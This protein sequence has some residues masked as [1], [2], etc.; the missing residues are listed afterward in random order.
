[1]SRCPTTWKDCAGM[2]RF[3]PQ[4]LQLGVM[5]AGV[6]LSGHALLLGAHMAAPHGH[7]SGNAH[8]FCFV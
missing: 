7:C 1:M 4:R 6:L 3:N 5:L 8:A 2:Q